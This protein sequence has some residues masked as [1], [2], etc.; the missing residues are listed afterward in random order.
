MDG[1][2]LVPEALAPTLVSQV[3]QATH[4]GHDKMEEFILKYF[5]ISWFSSL[6]TMES[7]NYCACSQVNSVPGHKNLQEYS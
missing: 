2:L 1:R 7:R 5:L 3:H 6:C 4:L